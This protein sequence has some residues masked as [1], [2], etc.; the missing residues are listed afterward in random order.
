MMGCDVKTVV[1]YGEK[2]GLKHMLSTMMK[3]SYNDDEKKSYSKVNADEY[4]EDILNAIRDNPLIT[5][6]EVREKLSKQYIWLYK[7]DRIW[8]ENSM[9]KRKNSNG[10]NGNMNVCWEDRDNTILELLKKEYN[11]L[12]QMNGNKRITKSLL[13][14]RIN[15][16]ALIEKKLDKLPK[17]KKFLDEVLESVEDYQIRRIDKVCSAMKEDGEELLKWKII[18]RAGLRDSYAERL[19]KQVKFS[20]LKY[21]KGK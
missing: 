6:Q 18:K 11:M 21:N 15:M 3:T 12:M 1:R 17:S 14:R 19:D 13:G 16:L 20:I 2:L 7:N 9:P 4:K 5:R 8:F 10:N